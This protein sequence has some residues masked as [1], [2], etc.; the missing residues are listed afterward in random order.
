MYIQSLLKLTLIFV[1]H[2]MPSH[3]QP[4]RKLRLLHEHMRHIFKQ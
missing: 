2:A 1:R 4:Y 3:T